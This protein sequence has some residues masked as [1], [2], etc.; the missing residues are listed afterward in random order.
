MLHLIRQNFLILGCR[1]PCA[2]VGAVPIQ[3]NET[4]KLQQRIR[5][6]KAKLT[7]MK[8]ETS[9]ALRLK[10]SAYDPRQSAKS[11]GAVFGAGILIFVFGFIII[12]DLPKLWFGIGRCIFILRTRNQPKNNSD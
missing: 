9:K 3:A 12:S 4:E 10:T 7:I 6:L 11:L 2:M 5:E 8:N 1:C